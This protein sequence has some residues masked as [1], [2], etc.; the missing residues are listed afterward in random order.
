MGRRIQITE[1]YLPNNTQN[2]ASCRI[3]IWFNT[4]FCHIR[5]KKKTQIL[6]EVKGDLED[7]FAGKQFICAQHSFL[8][9]S[10][11]RPSPI[12]SSWCM[13]DLL[14]QVASRKIT[15]GS[16]QEA[17]R[18]IEIAGLVMAGLEGLREF[19][20]SARRKNGGVESKEAFIL[21]LSNTGVGWGETWRDLWPWPHR[22][23]SIH[24]SKCSL[25][26]QS[27]GAPHMGRQQDT[28]SNSR[29]MD[30]TIQLLGSNWIFEKRFMIR[31]QQFW[32]TA[33]K[34]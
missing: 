33:I 26:C 23:N 8:L 27:L 29:W 21:S 9:Y 1:W 13:T 2:F 4:L 11:G 5:K 24:S 14:S 17:E 10:P 32:H 25:N 28:D 20:W 7:M 19:F 18:D 22:E 6:S 12:W 31:A 34:L 30:L 15:F 3:E 16:E